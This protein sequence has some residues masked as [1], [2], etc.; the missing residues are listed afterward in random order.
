ML[1][2]GLIIVQAEISVLY[3]QY[4][5]GISPNRCESHQKPTKQTGYAA[6]QEVADAKRLC[7][8]MSDRRSRLLG[9]VILIAA[10]LSAPTWN[11]HGEFE[12]SH[13]PTIYRPYASKEKCVGTRSER[14][15]GTA[16]CSHRPQSSA[17]SASYSRLLRR[18]KGGAAGGLTGY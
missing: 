14:L 6:K 13:A 15:R 5:Y 1:T 7:A 10:S 3:W 16:A 9:D 8:P 18:A 11:A 2:L 4:K 17:Q 12:D